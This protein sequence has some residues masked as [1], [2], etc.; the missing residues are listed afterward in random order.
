M[1][2]GAGVLPLGERTER[3]LPWDRMLLDDLRSVVRVWRYGSGLLETDG[4]LWPS[5]SCLNEGIGV[6]PVAS[7]LVTT[8]G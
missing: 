2:S 6:A 4:G 7:N 8:Q 1:Q 5:G 3:L